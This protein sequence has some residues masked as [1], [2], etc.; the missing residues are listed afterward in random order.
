VGDIT[1]IYVAGGYSNGANGFL[2]KDLS[3]GNVHIV[4]GIY[5]TNFINENKL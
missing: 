4:N 1:K 2:R 5:I 3:D